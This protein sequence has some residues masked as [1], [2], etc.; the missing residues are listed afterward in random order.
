[1]ISLTFSRI[2]LALLF[3]ICFVKM[4]FHFY[5]E[6]NWSSQ[7]WSSR[8]VSAG[9]WP[10]VLL[11]ILIINMIMIITIIIIII[12]VIIPALKSQSGHDQCMCTSD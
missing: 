8:T 9:R 7:N 6:K 2:T 4:D 5:L 3:I 10:R 11:S 12:I 1:M